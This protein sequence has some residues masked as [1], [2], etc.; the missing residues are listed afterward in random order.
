MLHH[1]AKLNTD[2][3]HFKG[4]NLTFIYTLRTLRPNV[5]AV[6]NYANDSTQPKIP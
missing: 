4:D 5:E 1:T 6:R 2:L 3:V